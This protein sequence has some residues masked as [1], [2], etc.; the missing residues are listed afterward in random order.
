MGLDCG[1]NSRTDSL[2]CKSKK[3]FYCFLAGWEVWQFINADGNQLYSKSGLSG[4]GSPPQSSPPLEFRRREPLLRSSEE[5]RRGLA[6]AA[7][8][9]AE[10]RGRPEAKPAQPPPSRR[11]KSRRRSA[12][13][14]QEETEAPPGHG[15]A[16][17]SRGQRQPPGRELKPPREPPRRRAG[18]C[19]A[20]RRVPSALGGLPRLAQA[21]RAEQRAGGARQR[22]VC[23][24]EVAGEKSPP[25]RPNALLAK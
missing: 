14:A 7:R 13:A 17:R 19:Q 8:K 15:S 4:A 9:E 18:E 10:G 24:A 21:L 23:S 22:R 6:R 3:E 5:R 20:P 12:G 1:R 2:Y 16:Q 25:Q 11:W